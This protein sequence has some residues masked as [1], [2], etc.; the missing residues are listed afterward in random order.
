MWYKLTY[1]EKRG[2]F[3]AEETE[4]NLIQEELSS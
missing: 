1:I 4:S 2:L 3:V